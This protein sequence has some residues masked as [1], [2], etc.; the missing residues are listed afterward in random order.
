[1]A[2]VPVPATA[3]AALAAPRAPL[4]RA[5]IALLTAAGA[6]VRGQE[7]F[8]RAGDESFREIPSDTPVTALEFGAGSYDHGAVNQ[9]PNCMFPL[10]RLRELAAAGE[11]GGL[12]AMHF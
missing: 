10:E 1:R 7:P 9:D 2:E 6:S 3:P 8:D 12:T 5:R 4:A 11:V